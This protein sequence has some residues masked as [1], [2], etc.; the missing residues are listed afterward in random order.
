MNLFL[1]LDFIEWVCENKEFDEIHY[2]YCKR[3]NCRL[4]DFEYIDILR[5][6]YNHPLVVVWRF[7]FN[8]LPK[9]KRYIIKLYG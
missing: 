2:E 3:V 8:I 9:I 5:Q 4:N 1:A 7:L 6:Q